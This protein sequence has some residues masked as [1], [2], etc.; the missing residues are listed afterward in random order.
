MKT[1]ASGKHG[2]RRMQ[3]YGSKIMSGYVNTRLQQ[4]RPSAEAVMVEGDNFLALER[5]RQHRRKPI[6]LARVKG[7]E[8]PTR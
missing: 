2:N 1:P 6:S 8:G 7:W 5:G 4:Q 3:M